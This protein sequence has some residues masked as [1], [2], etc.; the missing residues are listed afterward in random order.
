MMGFAQPAERETTDDGEALH[1]HAVTNEFTLVD[2]ESIQ[3]WT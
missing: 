3:G 2:V 1:H